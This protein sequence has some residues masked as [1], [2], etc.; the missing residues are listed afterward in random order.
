MTETTEQVVV[1][2]DLDAPVPCTVEREQDCPYEA[3][4]VVFLPCCGQQDGCCDI[5][6]EL[7]EQ[8]NEEARAIIRF[9]GPDVLACPSCGKDWVGV[10]WRAL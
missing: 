4:W 5:H 8:A 3:K 9:L 2:V 6:K 7:I 1:D 10:Q